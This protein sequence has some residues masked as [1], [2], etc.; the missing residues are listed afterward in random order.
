MARLAR[1]EGV[2]VGGSGGA[3]ACAALRVAPRLGAGKTIVTLFADGSERYL[4]QGIFDEV[5]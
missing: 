3:A 1:E 2:L 5:T 4:S